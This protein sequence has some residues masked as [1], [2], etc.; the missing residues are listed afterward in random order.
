M[1][2]KSE[3]GG[4]VLM[5]HSL[6]TLRVCPSDFSYPVYCIGDEKAEVSKGV[7]GQEASRCRNNSLGPA[8]G[9]CLQWAP[10]AQRWVRGHQPP[11]RVMTG[12]RRE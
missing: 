11:E 5:L 6:V 9:Q 12:W 3:R 8:R 2:G 10:G 1:G 4:V 7:Y